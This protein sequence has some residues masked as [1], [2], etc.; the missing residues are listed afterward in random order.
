MLVRLPGRLSDPAAAWP[1]AARA[2]LPGPGGVLLRAGDPRRC[3]RRPGRGVRQ[4]RGVRAA[5]RRWRRCQV[6][7]RRGSSRA[8]RPRPRRLAG[9]AARSRRAARARAL[10][11]PA[12]PRR[13]PTRPRRV[14]PAAV[15]QVRRPGG[16]GPARV[17]RAGRRLLDQDRPAGGDAAPAP[18]DSGPCSSSTRSRSPARRRTPGRRC[19][20]R[21]PG[22]ARSRSRGGWR[23]QASSTS[24]ASRAGTSG[25]SPPSSGWRRC[26]SRLQEAARASTAWCAGRYGQG[27]RELHQ[28]LA[29][30]LWRR[31]DEAELDA[32]H[33]AY[34]AVRGVRGAGR[35]D[36]LIDRGDR[37]GAAARLPLRARGPLGGGLRDHRRPAA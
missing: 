34:D 5:A 8:V 29:T 9:A 23:R 26:C 14:R 18:R 25:R 27:A 22:T 6:G 15:G 17:G 19:T 16:P 2:D 37:P 21:G 4:V 28:A 7:R 20:R 12:A 10:P 13:A 11:R 33:A 30:A 35:P 36:T 1:R 32:A 3:R 31:A 24:A